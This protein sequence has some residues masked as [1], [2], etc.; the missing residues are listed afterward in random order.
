MSTENIDY[1]ANSDSLDELVFQNRNKAYGAYDL[2]ASYKKLLTKS[3]F[4][5]GLIFGL[6]IAI[7]IGYIRYQEQ[8]EA[9]KKKEFFAEV[10]LTEI[11]DTNTPKEEEEKE[12]EKVYE[13]KKEEPVAQEEGG[14]LPVRED[15]QQIEIVRD[16]VPEVTANPKKEE[17]VATVEQRQTSTTGTVNQAGTQTTGYA[18]GTQ[19]TPGQGT[20]GIGT[21]TGKGTGKDTANT[22]TQGNPSKDVVHTKVD[23]EAEFPGGGLSKFRSTFSN[24]FDTG[25]VEADGT[26]KC[27]VTFVVE[28]DG[29][30]TDVKATGSNSDMN[31]EAIRVVRSIK[32]KWV[33]AEVDGQKVRSRFTFPVTMNFESY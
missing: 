23:K 27:T 6:L 7:P 17:T 4:I 20:G 8:K 28:K 24:S 13:Q 30:L 29:S 31:R 5:G 18:G 15:V 32:A 2:R 1:I 16:V 3:F 9:E 12:D 22:T 25:A 26:I 14:G 21:G 33:P 10:D 19:G 11:K